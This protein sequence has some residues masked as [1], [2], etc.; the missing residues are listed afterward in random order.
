MS[1][2]RRAL[3]VT[4]VVVVST[5]AFAAIRT[6]VPA[7]LA[8]GTTIVVSGQ[9]FSTKP[10]VWLDLSGRKIPLAV[11]KGATDLHFTAKLAS[12]PKGAHGL[13]TLDVLPHGA[14]TPF[15][16]AGLFIELPAISTVSPA[17][18]SAN[19][20]I[21]INGAHFGTAKGRVRFGGVAGHVVKWNDTSI[22]VKAPKQGKSVPAGTK[23]DVT[24]L[25]SAG[26]VVDP[27][28]FTTQ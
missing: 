5:L 25:N 18:A 13:C 17:S 2:S 7:R 4:S 28:A 20:L 11:Q 8:V 27:G 14:S 22:T 19:T 9:G 1:D 24:V 3:V 23:L 12:I 16:A 6:A 26:S 21:T 10:K 15:T